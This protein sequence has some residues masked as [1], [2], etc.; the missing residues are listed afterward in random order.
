[1][2]EPTADNTSLLLGRVKAETEAGEILA[3][4]EAV[5]QSLPLVGMPFSA[6]FA[7]REERRRKRVEE[8]LNALDERLRTAELRLDRSVEDLRGLED[9]LEGWID[10]AERP[11]SAA[12]R[13]LLVS[14][15][16]GAVREPTRFDEQRYFLRVCRE[17]EDIDLEN[18]LRW[19][20][21]SIM[22]PFIPPD[23]GVRGAVYAGS[24]QRLHQWGL[25]ETRTVPARPA[26]PG[27]SGLP[28]RE[29]LE[30]TELGLRFIAMMKGSSL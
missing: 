17:L 9:F 19:S 28:S 27:T 11:A 6:A 8:M 29:R 26:Y 15:A 1:M 12:K 30:V 2:I 3:A 21:A 22:N 18:L 13:E 24:M 14:I 23:S 7:I 25:M 5:L 10:Q 16:E 20:G 4:G